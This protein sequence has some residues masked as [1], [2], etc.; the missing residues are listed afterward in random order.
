[1]AEVVDL[2]ALVEALEVILSKP[3]LLFSLMKCMMVMNLWCMSNVE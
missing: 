2:E 3:E 1:M